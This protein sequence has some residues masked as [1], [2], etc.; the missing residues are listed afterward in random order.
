MNFHNK[1]WMEI[2]VKIE[3][4]LNIFRR[5]KRLV[6]R[7]EDE[8]K[9]RENADVSAQYNIVNSIRKSHCESISSVVMRICH[10]R[11][12]IPIPL[13]GETVFS[14]ENNSKY[15]ISHPNL[16]KKREETDFIYFRKSIFSIFFRIFWYTKILSH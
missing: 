1:L 14:M 6:K 8:E 4:C 16:I 7:E 12:S 9:K 2:A 10:T 11:L 3:I 13:L 5:H 15:E